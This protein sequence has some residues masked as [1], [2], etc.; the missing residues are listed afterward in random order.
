MMSLNREDDGVTVLRLVQ[1]IC[2]STMLA[3]MVIAGNFSISK[4][5]VNIVNIDVLKSVLPYDLGKG[6]V[7]M[8]FPFKGGM[9][10]ENLL[11]PWFC[12]DAP[13]SRCAD[14][15][16]RTEVWR[17]ILAGNNE[18][19]R[20]FIWQVIKQ[21]N[22]R[23]MDYVLA[24]KIAIQS[25]NEVMVDAIIEQVNDPKI[26][27]NL[28]DWAMSRARRDIMIKFYVKAARRA[29]ND[30]KIAVRVA[31]LLISE[32]DYN[33]AIEIVSRSLAN[34]PENLDL[35]FVLAHAL[36]GQQQYQKAIDLLLDVVQEIPSSGAY[37]LLSTAQLGIG[38]WEL[39]VESCRQ[40]LSLDSENLWAMYL[41]GRSLHELNH[42]EKAAFWWRKALIIDPFFQPALDALGISD[43]KK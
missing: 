30:I 28:G 2:I 23:S 32:S 4:L 14:E 16:W 37:A 12:G 40:A 3:L 7:T 1:I 38:Q 24:I 6:S 41:L 27:L 43:P 8:D 25:D 42:E 35:K 22:A 10:N 36:V 5:L 13:P 26:L 21:P 20:Q 11:T 31:E 34:H 39:A 18:R 9:Q 19:A 33:Q 29:P 15:L 17:A